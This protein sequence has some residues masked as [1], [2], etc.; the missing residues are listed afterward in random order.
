MFFY[1][2]SKVWSY[3]KK[4][5]TGCEW[6]V[7]SNIFRFKVLHFVWSDTQRKRWGPG[8]WSAPLPPMKR[9]ILELQHLTLSTLTQCSLQTKQGVS[10]SRSSVRY[11]CISNFYKTWIIRHKLNY[12]M[13]LLPS[14]ITI[15]RVSNITDWNILRR[16]HSLAC[17]SCLWYLVPWY[18]LCT[19]AHWCTRACFA[20]MLRGAA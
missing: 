4:N 9:I 20:L 8:A 17:I 12:D 1:I 19:S 3:W 6:Q 15:Q 14:K 16:S 7:I 2:T 10:D 18:A 13:Y 5:F 11:M